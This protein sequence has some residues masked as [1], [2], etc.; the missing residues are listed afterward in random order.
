MRPECLVLT[1]VLFLPQGGSC[2]AHGLCKSLML[3]KGDLNMG[4]LLREIAH[5]P[6]L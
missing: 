6:S 1:K 2:A 5:E 4:W 3:G